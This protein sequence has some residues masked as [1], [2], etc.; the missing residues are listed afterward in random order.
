MRAS[1]RG[2]TLIELLVALAILALMALV[3]WRGLDAMTRAHS[4]IQERGDALLTLQ[5][6]LAQWAAD[7]DAQVAL[8]PNPARLDQFVLTIE[9]PTELSEKDVEGVRRSAEKCLVKN[10]MLMPPSISLT[11][12]AHSAALS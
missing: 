4:H 11:V 2:F 6:G 9:T 12:Q 5:A 8:A 10:T 3:S 1:N 7:L